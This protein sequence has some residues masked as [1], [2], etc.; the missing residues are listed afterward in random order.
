MNLSS[1]YPL[2]LIRNGIPYDYP[3]LAADR[4]VDVVVMG[5]GI[6]GALTAYYLCKSGVNCLL[7]DARSI[8]L[9]STC[10][11][12]SLL[13][14]EIDVPLY[15]LCEKIGKTKAER[16]YHLSGEAINTLEK[17]CDAI[18]FNNFHHS[19]SVYFA[20]ARKD[21]SHLEKE[22]EARLTSGFD[23]RWADAAELRNNYGLVAP[24]AIISS[25]AAQTNAYTLSHALHQYNIKKGMEVYD[26]TPV[27]KIDHNKRGVVLIT[28]EG[29]KI[30]CKKLVYATGYESL[31]Y[32]DQKIAR[33]SATYATASQ[34]F[35]N[36]HF[37]WNDLT[38]FWNTADP[39][40]YMRLTN[41]RR[42]IAGGR[43]E[44]FTSDKKRDALIEQKGKQLSKD[45][46]RHFPVVPF[47]KE[48]SWTGL[49][50]S[51]KDGLPFIGSYNKLSNSLFA[52][53]FGG[54]GITFSVLA[55]EMTRDAVK[56]KKNKDASLFA[57]TR[58]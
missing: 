6:S 34:Q 58:L 52:L 43:D 46:T 3:Q 20:A 50:A 56:G 25:L 31:Q 37:F 18:G 38:M 23:I 40:F 24:A 53:G 26:R 14:Y 32:I 5:G 39:Y 1:G 16:S 4:E 2:D 8:G 44:P 57:F 22:Y 54:N 47:K 35:N 17:I 48:F 15:R 55:A 28:S 45:F 13:Q 10:A 9:G 29:Y 30:R 33:L 42:I 19:S 12:T 51:T 49:F 11:S 41:D 27:V 7:V 36:D 21:I